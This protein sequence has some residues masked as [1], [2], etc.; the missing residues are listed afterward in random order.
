MN[1]DE[2]ESIN[3]ELFKIYSSI[4]FRKI[5]QIKYIE[6]VLSPFV[7]EHPELKKVLDIIERWKPKLGEQEHE[8]HHIQKS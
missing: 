8:S 6:A 5:E 4:K 7:P 3:M 2:F 1:H